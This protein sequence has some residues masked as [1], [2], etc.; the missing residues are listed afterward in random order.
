MQSAK[1]EHTPEPSLRPSRE[2]VA[3]ASC[4]PQIASF[5]SSTT[6]SRDAADA[7]ALEDSTARALVFGAPLADASALRLRL[8]PATAVSE[9]LAPGD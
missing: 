7:N 1:R 9:Q 6:L 2:N 4:R 8:W 5:A 3:E